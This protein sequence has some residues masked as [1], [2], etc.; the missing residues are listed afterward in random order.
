MSKHKSKFKDSENVSSIYTAESQ[1]LIYM[2]GRI[3][4]S[5]IIVKHLKHLCPLLI[6]MCAD[7]I[8]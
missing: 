1:H 2:W 4:D 3:I 5:D 7:M 6:F 8:F